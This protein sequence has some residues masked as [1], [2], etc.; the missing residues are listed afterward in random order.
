MSMFK[1]FRIFAPLLVLLALPLVFDSTPTQILKLRS[2]D[3]FVKE[4]EPSGNFV[5][6]N[7]SQQDLED[8][9][10]WPLTRQQLADIH[11]DLLN[12][13][14]IGVGYGMVFP[15]PSRTGN[16]E[17]FAEALSY[18]PSV[19]AMYENGSGHYPPTTGT[20]IK[21][22]NIGGMMST[23]VKENLSILA[24]NSLQGIAI[25]PTEVDNLVRQ[26]PLIVRSPD[27]WIPSF[28]TQIYKA[29]FDVRSYI[30][31]TNEL[32]IQEIAIR[33]IP[34]VKTDSLGRKWIS[35]VKTPQTDL[36]EMAVAG[37]YAIVGTDSGGILPKIAV[38]VGLLEPH[39]IQAAL[40]ESILI[41]DS[42]YIPD[43]SLAAEVAILLL[44]VAL[45]WLL[46]QSLGLTFGIT[47]AVGIMSLTAYGGISMIRAGILVDTTWA[48]ISQFISGSVSFYLRFREQFKL[49]QQIEKQFGTY[50][51]KRM[52]AKLKKDPDLLKLGGE[53][54]Y[55]TYMFSDLRNFTAMSEKL[56]PEKTT[57]VINKILSAQVRIAQARGAMTDKFIGDAAMFI[58]SAPLDL[59]NHEDAAVLSAI[60]IQ[61]EITKVSAELVEEGL[62]PV[63]I[64]LGIQTGPSTVANIGSTD[65]DRFDYSAIGSPVNEAARLESSCKTVGVNILIGEATAKNCSID[66]KELPSIKAKGVSAP[67]RIWTPTDI[68]D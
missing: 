29:L 34:P 39:K 47:L 40:A 52:V 50:L 46:T 26:I 28:G 4:Q 19:L 67:L 27:G 49:R 32:G 30:I 31:T 37:K 55:C 36:Q 13:G 8:L 41:Q 38:P 7:I 17:V 51:D 42:P 62:P 14:A 48:L 9:G 11:I 59:E 1:N 44:S 56:G 23:G 5:I 33:G 58:Y 45:I 60:E 22:E 43:W 65:P 18:G 53:I 24:Q 6:V 25:A 20:V 35:W 66:L 3:N 12:K 64:G 15:F 68:L 63:A 16:D 54:R 57:Y 61:Q 10:G 2:F 21:G